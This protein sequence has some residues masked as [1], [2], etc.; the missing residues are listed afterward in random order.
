VVDNFA[1]KELRV[2]ESEVLQRR[3]L[4]PLTECRREMASGQRSAHKPELI[5]RLRAIGKEAV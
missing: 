2:R 5:G 1:S 4:N 3:T